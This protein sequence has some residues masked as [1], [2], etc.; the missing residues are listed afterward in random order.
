MHATAQPGALSRRSFLVGSGAVT[1]GLAF[2]RL[3][4]A[5]AQGAGFSPVA[6]VAIAADN[7]ATIYSPASEMGQGT[8]T[9]IPMVFAE[10][11]ELDWNKVRVVQAPP[12]PRL[13]GN[14]RFGGGLTTGASRTVQGY[15]EPL[16]LAGL[17]GRLVMLGA[18]ASAWG[19]PV[20]E[21]RAENSTVV[22]V[23]S[24]RRVSYGELAKTATAPAELPKVDKTMLKPMAQFKIIGKD[25][26][27]VDVEAKTNGTAVYGIDVRLPGMLYASLLPAP[28]QGE[29]AESV[30]DA[31]A[32]AVP[33][34][35][36]VVTLPTGVAV[37]ADSF[38]TARKARE[39]LKV[40]WTRSAKARAYDS[41]AAMKEFVARAENLADAGVT[42]HQ[43][44]DA[45]TAIAGAA[46]TFK[47]TYTSEHVAQFT[48]EPMNCT[49][50]VDGERIE[51][52]VPSQTVGFVVGGVAAAGGFKS[53]NVKVNIT[54]LG[55]GYGRR[56]EAEY[57]VDAA[58][59]AKA[60]PGV[61]VQLI[62]TRE[63]DMHRSKPR[64][65]TAQH[66]IAGVDA[67][68]RIVGL[69]HRVTAEQ[70]YGR[71]LPGPFKAG[72]S[73][74]VP[75]MEGSEG[76]YDFGSHLV[77]QCL[78]D[79]G[80]A[81][82]FWRGVGPGYL[83][84]ALETLI[85]EIA[86]AYHRDPLQARLELLAKSPRAQAVLREVAA[87]SQWTRAR[88]AGRALGMAFSDTWNSFIGMVVDL[89]LDQGKPVVHKIWAAVDCGHALTPRNIQTQI[90][91][92]A[93]F[94]MSAALGEKLT[95]KGGEPQ[96]K[97]LD[98]YPL[99]RANATPEVE[100]KVMPTDHYPGGIGEVGLPPVAPAM[101][102]A[103]A[104]LTGKRLRTLPFPATVA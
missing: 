30:D 75:V 20:A 45:P 26:P 96:Q 19:V 65:M 69:Q 22:H 73:K 62:W 40:T 7:T 31:A 103:I 13:F 8:M 24:G 35:K 57:A 32:K 95:Y 82:S 97:N 51:L 88:P 2:G 11:M 27:R 100:V 28:V 37:V 17:Q 87:M 6:W 58:L 77:Q 15:Y 52:W 9:A 83:K 48:M 104:R 43:H 90:E 89:S 76:V 55:G 86:T 4:Q 16:R 85:D 3:P 12:N 92:S 53:E 47:A 70:I 61:P 1:V 59:I 98:T 64:P 46:R 66:L 101:A 54:L 34:V 36:A 33:G 38:H 60:V 81:C 56:V 42:W 71:V 74:D 50:K 102:N 41:D 68:G 93:L 99:L 78:E 5:H 80:I 67:Q 72:G 49:A 10:E 91:G 29:R 25:L 23:P 21:L 14:P 79:R 63:D 18:A 44:G 94:G 84:F 39:L